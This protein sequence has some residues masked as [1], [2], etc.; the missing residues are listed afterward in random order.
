MKYAGYLFL[1]LL[2]IISCSQPTEKIFQEMR[3][4]EYQRN[5]NPDKFITWLNSKNEKVR[6]QAVETLGRMQDTT[7]LLWIVN[8]LGDESPLVRK[9]AAWALG[10]YFSPIAEQPVLDAVRIENNHEV[11]IALIEALGKVGTDKT[12]LYLRDFVESKDL[13]EERTASIACGIMAYRGYVPYKAINSL[14]LILQTT[15]DDRVRWSAAY[16]LYRAGSPVQFKGLFE[17]LAEADPLTRFF[18]LKA[19]TVISQVMQTPQYQR[20]K[21]T[22]I[23][24]DATR[25]IASDE[26]YDRLARTL[27]DTAW[28]VRMTD[29]QVMGQLS[30]PYLWKDIINAAND[31]H[32][33]VRY[34]A[35][36]AISRY[37]NKA[38]EKW[39]I[40]YIS[41]TK[42][43]REKGIAL[44]KLGSLN[45]ARALRIVQSTIDRVQWPE[46]YYHIKTLEKISTRAS[47][48]ILMEL[49][50]AE[51]AA[52]ASL[53]MEALS[54][55]TEIPVSFFLN[56]L[57]RHDPSITTI[58]ATTL[59]FRGSEEAVPLLIDSYRHFQAPRD[60]EPMEAIL[61]ALDSIRSPQAVAFLEGELQNPFPPIRQAAWQALKH[62]T[63]KEYTL[64]D[65]GKQSLTRYDFPPVDP[66]SRLLVKFTTTKG[67]FAVELY[68]DKAPVTVANFVQ[69]VKSGFYNGIYFHRVVP[70]FVV[71]AGDPRGDG[72]GGPGYTIPCEYNDIFYERG[73]LGMAHAGKDTGGSQ[74]FIT[75][76]PQPHLNGRH[77]AFGRVVGGMK[78]IDRLE[79]FDKIEK[80][81]LVQN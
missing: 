20:Y 39:L 21:D 25:L 27:Q 75:H 18:D 44:Q 64:P 3:Q 49:A 50:N 7:A 33:Y 59:S 24:Q 76:T 35:I 10:E 17:S 36:E 46:N 52:Q 9:A 71:Q 61:T 28:Y 51:N 45:A 54:N 81:E 4:L 80:A 2:L 62:I 60:L 43:W 48:K 19:L 58:V 32:P 12:Y 11:K 55:R 42:N 56:K 23:M 57:K 8:R 72:W 68:P 77:T 37:K 34:A 78:V 22:K 26:F 15:R 74:F 14:A 38:A 70:G 30:V 40:K 13:D 67:D 5:P 53:A 66:Q 69:L 29:L 1:F 65:T 6:Q 16:A 41:N 47:D 73:V 63:G 79:I 31:E